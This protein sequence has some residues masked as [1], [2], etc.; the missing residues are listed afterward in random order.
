M[1]S[2]S[3]SLSLS[4]YAC[5]G[6]QRVASLESSVASRC[7]QTEVQEAKVAEEAKQ[8]SRRVAALTEGAESAAQIA[9]KIK[10][11]EVALKTRE[12]ETS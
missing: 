5:G 1:L 11:A 7:S 8:L 9:D 6:S 12:V 10:E 2:L 3:L 4:V